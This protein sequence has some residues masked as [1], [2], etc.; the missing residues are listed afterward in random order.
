MKEKVWKK[1]IDIIFIYSLILRLVEGKTWQ[2]LGLVQYIV[3]PFVLLFAIIE[4]Y[5]ILREKR[6]R[7]FMWELIFYSVYIVLF[8]VLCIKSFVC[9]I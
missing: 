4:L 1:L 6:Y 2:T 5:S 9:Q 8:L 7:L 3:Y